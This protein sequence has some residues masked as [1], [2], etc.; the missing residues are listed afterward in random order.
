MKILVVF[1]GG[2][3]GSTVQSGVISPNSENS[4]L[5]LSMYSKLDDKTE[6][7]GVQPYNILSE[8]LCADNL[9]MLYECL[10]SYD[11]GEFDGV[12][13]THGTDTLQYTSAYLSYVMSNAELPIV[14]VSANYPLSDSRSN[15]LENFCSAVDF[16]KAK[17]GIGV[18]VAYKNNGEDAKIHRASRL[19]P[20]LP[21]SDFVHSV[22]F[23]EY[24]K[25]TERSFVKNESYVE[26]KDEIILNTKYK[27]TDESNVLFIKPNIGVSY[28]TL[29]SKVKAILLEGFHSGT[30][31]T[32]GDRFSDFCNRAK[33]LDIPIFLTGACK[34]FY[35]ESK[36]LFDSL[37]IKVLPMASPI[38]MYVK[39]WLLNR[40]EI[41]NVFL[42]CGYDFV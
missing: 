17:V 39:L 2:T 16:I 21:Y 36:T 14:I 13:V 20:H 7:V 6:F 28:P 40:E 11:F 26:T 38:A 19:L 24:G 10:N 32:A 8:N 22:D 37:N 12:I 35:Y 9:V 23:C 34:G 15:G 1:T 31:N 29:N 4:Y 5:L 25:I 18:F 42:P 27:L 33:E 3:I 30:L 41:N